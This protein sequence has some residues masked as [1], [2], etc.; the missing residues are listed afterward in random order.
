MIEMT[1]KKAFLKA[2]E[3]TL[4][5]SELKALSSVSLERSLTDKEY[6]RMIALKGT[7]FGVVG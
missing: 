5:L 7:V 3:N 1:D 2:F 6:N 4:A